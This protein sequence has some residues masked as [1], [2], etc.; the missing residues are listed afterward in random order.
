MIGIIDVGGGMKAIYSAGILD[1]CL[2]NKIY[3]DYALGVS[4]GSGNLATYTARQRG[5]N[6]IFYTDYTFRKEYMSVSNFFKKGEYC[7]LDYPYSILSN[8]DGESPLDYKRLM[9]SSTDLNVVATDAETGKPVY[10]NQNKMKKNDYWIFKASSTIPVVSKPFERDGKRYYDGGI[11]DPIPIKKALEDGCEKVVV[12]LSRPK[13][14][15]KS[16]KKSDKFSKFVIREYPKTIDAIYSRASRY[17]KILE[18]LLK[19]E[20]LKEKVLVLGPEDNFGIDTLSKNKDALEK[21][22]KMGYEDGIL[23][24]EFLYDK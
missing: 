3:F 12:V 14:F 6:Y 9:D 2:D 19:D 13:D 22:Y 5:R 24:K 16:L 23:V 21:I 7:D 4:A 20:S 15:R 10:I 18:D 1:Y 8:D 11:A 17:N